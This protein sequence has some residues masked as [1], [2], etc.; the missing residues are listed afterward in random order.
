MPTNDTRQNERLSCGG[1]EQTLTK[2]YFI[3]WVCPAGR[4]NP[5]KDP[6]WFLKD[7]RHGRGKRR[8]WKL[9]TH[10]FGIY[11]FDKLADAKR[12]A[13]CARIK[14]FR[15]TRDHYIV[16]IVEVREV[17]VKRKT[18]DVHTRPG[19]NPLMVLA[20]EAD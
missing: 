1:Y 5:R 20:L 16:E 11:K 4:N 19:V 18:Y 6:V 9:E 2:T 7:Q 13:K 3:V 15:E 12:A 8:I 14:K 17:E 10:D